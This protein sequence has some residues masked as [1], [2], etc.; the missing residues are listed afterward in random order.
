MKHAWLLTLIALGGCNT[1]RTTAID[2]C[3][4]DTLVVNPDRPMKGVPISL[5]VPTHLELRVIETT[6]WEKQD[7]PGKKPTLVPL[8]TCRATRSVDHELCYTEKVFLVD[9][10]R[11]GAGL[12]N[13]GFT[14][15]SNESEKGEDA[16]KGYLRKVEY[17]IDDTTIKE[18]ANLVSNVLGLVTAFQTG[19]ND[20]RPN[21]GALISTDRTVAFARFDINSCSFEEEVSS[22][23][24]TH[25]NHAACQTSL[26]PT[27]CAKSASQ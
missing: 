9:P 27:V 7:N 6:Y 21:S 10:V 15:T 12:Q 13:Y 11:P 16:G 14:F 18:S 26:C 1:F 20:A 19:S 22:F 5:R 24:D 17:K 23:L 8:S 25:V 4:N 3:E 2:R